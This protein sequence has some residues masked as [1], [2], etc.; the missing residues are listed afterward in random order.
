MFEIFLDHD[1]SFENFVQIPD[2]YFKYFVLFV[3]WV[4]YLFYVLVFCQMYTWE[5][6]SSILWASLC[7]VNFFIF[8]FYYYLLF[9]KSRSFYSFM[10]SHLSVGFDS[11]INGALFQTSFPIP[12]SCRIL[13]VFIVSFSI[14]DFMC[15]SLIHLV[16]VFVQGGRYGSSS[17]FYVWT[18]KSP[19]Y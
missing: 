7:M 14:S 11:W 10:K 1:I 4:L 19:Q 12:V 16:L 8:I 9:Y 17:F 3:F 5:R 2:T 15:R 18:S 6:F 13:S